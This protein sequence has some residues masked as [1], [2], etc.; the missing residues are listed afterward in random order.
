MFINALIN[1]S[2]NPGLI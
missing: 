1:L 2:P